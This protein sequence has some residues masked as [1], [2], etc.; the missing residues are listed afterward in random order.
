MIADI[1][2]INR[3]RYD[4]Y[5]AVMRGAIQANDGRYLVRTS[6]VEVVEGNWVPPRLVVIE[7]PGTGAAHA[8]RASPEY[9]E[10]RRVCANAAMVDMVMVEGIDPP[11]PALP[12][13]GLPSYLISDTRI[14]NPERF[15]E[16][17]RTAARELTQHGGRYLVRDGSIE[18]I[19]GG[20][21]PSRLSMVEYPS[22]AVLDARLASDEYSRT[23]D[24]RANAAMVDR[25]LVEG[26]PP[27]AG[28]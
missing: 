11:A 14:I 18:V 28:L 9:T 22:R 17:R 15:E 12:D 21:Q 3:Q 25:V 2:I 13:T 5:R 4:E 6:K 27:E 1:R 10:A 23:R 8:F 24:L 16:Y 19:E 7:F 26:W 20:W